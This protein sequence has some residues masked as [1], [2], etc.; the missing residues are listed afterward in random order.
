MFLP[1]VF[2]CVVLQKHADKPIIEAC[3]WNLSADNPATQA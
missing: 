2:L 3:S 1:A